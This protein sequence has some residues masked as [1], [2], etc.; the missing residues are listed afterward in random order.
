MS[1]REDYNC[2]PITGRPITRRTVLRGAGAALALPLLEAMAPG[3]ALA[4]TP[5][6]ASSAASV[7]GQ[8]AP[9]RTMFLYLP[10][11]AI[12]DH[13][14]PKEVGSDYTLPK[15]LEPLTN[16]K[17]DLLVLSGLAHDKARANGDGPG[18]HA[19]SAGTFLTGVQL[20]K[21]DGRDIRAA[22]SVD[23]IAAEHVGHD[24]PL[25][26]LELG[27]ERG[28]QAGNCD[29]GYSCAYSTNVSW[30]TPHLP[31]TKEIRPRLVFERLF[32]DMSRVGDKHAAARRRKHRKSVLD[33]VREEA[34][35]LRR[36]L[37]GTDDRKLEEYMASVRDVERRLEVTERLS[38]RELPPEMDLPQGVP[39]EYVEHVRLMS[40]LM[41]LALATDS[42]RVVS[43]MYGNGASNRPYPQIGVRAGH[44]DLTH[45]ENKQKKIDAVAKINR[46]HMQQL[47]YLLEKMKSVQEGDSNLLDNSMVLCG[48]GISD[49]NR[50]AHHDL[51]I[52]LA[53]HAGGKLKSGRHLRYAKHT[54][55][56]NLYLSMLDRI[57]VSSDR[58][59][60]S[61]DRLSD[62]S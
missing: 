23:Q 39:H 5:A 6:T 34:R 41:V 51:P 62:L 4:G 7:A 19:R 46:F 59:G 54:P 10:N 48:S 28:K 24:T 36:Q 9:L 17:D 29:S 60:D 21:T 26:S 13:W 12:M 27:I 43:F 49:G 2:R 1:N 35:S 20:R 8:G 14:T 18:D 22:T 31:M 61:T 15:T 30:R 42:T 50:H 32:G 16:V 37:G 25:A 58:F 56:C 45:H 11:G 55:L 38:N 53:G 44:H 52:L 40:D 57:G 3:V 33:S 47:A